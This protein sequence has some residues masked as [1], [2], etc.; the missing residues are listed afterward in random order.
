MR[1]LSLLAV[2]SMA[3]G[4]AGQAAAAEPPAVGRWRTIDDETNTERS[5]VEIFTAQGG[6][7][8]GRIVKV[9]L[10]PDEKPGAVCE[11]CEGPHKDQ[12]IEGLVFL[13]GLKPDG[14]SWSGGAILDPKNGKIY[15]ARLRLAEEG[16]KLNVRGYIG[17]PLLGRSQV[18]LRD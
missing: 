16:K 18:W 3:L 17:T 5:I 15:N 9:F 13:W 14:D 10:R 1:Y 11:K 4:L 7:L 6:E 2:L 12:P 8:Q